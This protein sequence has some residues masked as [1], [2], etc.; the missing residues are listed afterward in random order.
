MKYRLLQYIYIIISV[1]IFSVIA[2]CSQRNEILVDDKYADFAH[3]ASVSIK[4]RYDLNFAESAV[5]K[6][7][8]QFDAMLGIMNISEDTSQSVAL[9]L[10]SPVVAAFVEDVDSILP[11]GDEISEDIAFIINQAAKEGINLPANS[12]ATAIWGKAQSIL[13]VDSVMF[14]GLNHY[15]GSQ[16]PAYA[17]LP[18]YRRSVKTSEML[19]YDIAEALVATAYPF[20]YNDSSTVINRL[21]YEGA[22]IASKMTLV[23]DAS[24]SDALGYNRE[25]LQWLIDNEGEL[26]RKLV[27]SK[28]I[29]DRSST[30]SDRL[31]LP[32]PTTNVLS[33]DCPGRAGRYIGYRILESYMK[34]HRD[35]SLTQLLSREF[36]GRIN[37]LVDTNYNPL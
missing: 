19:P 18:E 24:L 3:I 32:S 33:P 30:V 31:V 2:G 35:A 36:Y 26:W 16:H 23:K 10:D 12:Y 8:P 11:S 25:Q 17:G 22:L 20:E 7:R 9:W 13:F 37:P 5:S 15:L 4:S 27:G 6:H 14:I 1:V 29:F 34:S 21:I 28:M